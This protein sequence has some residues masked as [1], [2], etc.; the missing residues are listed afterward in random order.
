MIRL[1]CCLKLR[2]KFSL[3]TLVDAFVLA[4]ARKLQAKILT[5]DKQFRHFEE[6]V[7]LE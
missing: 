3:P 1:V 6:S 4:T 5:G 7:M 2:N